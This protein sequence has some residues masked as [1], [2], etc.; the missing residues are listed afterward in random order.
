[1]RLTYLYAL[2]EMSDTF[3]IRIRS[4]SL[5]SIF[6]SSFIQKTQQYTA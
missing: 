2:N 6:K 5:S 4:I 1:M 3:C